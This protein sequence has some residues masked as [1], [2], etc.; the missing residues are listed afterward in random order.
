MMRALAA[1]IL[2]AGVLAW[3]ANA[4]A[5][6]DPPAPEPPPE[7]VEEEEG[8]EGFVLPAGTE[9][10]PQLVFMGY[11]DMGYAIAEG[12][13]TSYP[14]NDTRL[15]VDYGVDTFAPAVNSRGDVASTESGNLYNNGFIPR[16]V[17]TAG[18]PSFLLNTVNFDARYQSTRAPIMAFTRMQLLPRWGGKG[19]GN[20]TL[21]YVEQAFGRVTPISGTEFFVSAGK[22]DSVFGIE[23]LEN[24]ANFRTG[25]TPSLF[26][27]Y[28][29]GTSLGLKAFYRHQIAPLWSAVSLNVSATNSGNFIEA[30]QPPDVSFTGRPVFSARLGYELNLPFMQVKLGG[31]FMDGPRNDQR[32]KSAKQRMWGADARLY[33]AGIALSGEWVDVKEELGAGGKDTGLG[34]YPIASEFEARGFWAQG[35]YAWPAHIGPL[36]TVTVYSRYEQRRAEFAGFRPL[37]VARLTGGFRVDL[38]DSL[39]LKGEVLFNQ[40]LD[41]APKVDN[42]VLT[43][44]VIFSW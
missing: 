35:A 44:S 42:D 19:R 9:T 18:R 13:G 20:E 34:S 33:V 21:V 3:G 40:E 26:A 37:K 16:S 28:T 41:G 23:Y 32:S 17:Q 11:I 29:T 5:A 25:I 30:L 22:F 39:I 43:S 12:D 2:G 38:W 31:S 24:Q 8:P 6:Q 10:T 14:P 7:T 27:R 4:P 1:A 36:T 15:P